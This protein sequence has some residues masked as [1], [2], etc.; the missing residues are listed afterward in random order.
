MDVLETIAS[1]LPPEISSTDSE[2]NARHSNRIYN[3][4]I[5]I[6]TLY[7]NTKIAANFVTAIL[8]AEKGT[9]DTMKRCTK[10]IQMSRG[11]HSPCSLFVEPRT[12]QLSV[13]P[14]FA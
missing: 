13:R 6:K 4:F 12:L 11:S 14:S 10:F 7:T 1:D 3:Q 9:G 2:A 8:A 5:N